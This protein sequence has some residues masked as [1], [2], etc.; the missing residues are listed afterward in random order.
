MGTTTAAIALG[1]ALLVGANY[2]SARH[3]LR[4][5]WTKTGIYSLSETTK[6]LVR[7]LTRPVRITL[8]MTDRSR[9][10]TPVRELLNRYQQLSPKIEVEELDPQRNP[11]RAQQLVQDFGIRQDT[12]VFRSGE[13]KKYVEEEKLAEFDFSS[14]APGG[15][16]PIRAFKGEEAF[17]SAILAVTEAKT[18]KVYFSQGHGEP[19]LDSPE[20]GRGFAEVKQLLERDNLLVGAWESLGK[21]EIPADAGAVVVAGPRTAFLEPEAAALDKYLAEGGRVL[22]LLDPVLPG[23]GAPPADLGLGKILAAHGMKANADLVID[24]ANAVPLVGPETLIANRY[25][26]HAIVRALSAEGL[27]VVFPVARSLGRTEPAPK[28]WTA[29][30]LVETSGDGWGET[31]LARL[32]EGV[33]KDP[34]DN[35]GP[36]PIAFAAAPADD[37]DAAE[38]S[39]R[40]VAVGN[41]R[42][43]QNGSLSNAGNANLFLNSIH[44]LTGS[45]RRIGIAPKTPEQAS[46]ALTQAQVRRIGLLSVFGLPGL[47]VLLGVWVWYRRRD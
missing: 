21:G 8:F 42:F 31:A 25:G 11:V 17:T 24:P 30:M 16:P 38:K 35:Q 4:G 23:P 29:T 5:D 34:Q 37:K 13:K 22:L 45:E 20:R 19:S 27:P 9:L 6:K 40:L 3:W 28:G 26:S 44:W 7:G 39:A 32:E 36:V 14:A 10:Y 2:L 46:L 43:A 1:A 12:V 47:A 15:S 33:R 18:P 41:S